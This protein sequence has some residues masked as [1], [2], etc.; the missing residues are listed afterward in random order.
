[1]VNSVWALCMQNRMVLDGTLSDRLRQQRNA[2][3]IVD[4]TVIHHN[5]NTMASYSD[6]ICYDNFMIIVEGGGLGFG[7]TLHY[8]QTR[9]HH[10]NRRCWLRYQSLKNEHRHTLANDEIETISIAGWTDLLRRFYLMARSN[11]L[12]TNAIKHRCDRENTDIQEHRFGLNEAQC[13]NTELLHEMT[14]T[15]YHAIDSKYWYQDQYIFI[16]VIDHNM[17]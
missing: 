9:I 15:V 13:E 10:E 11:V 3:V 4:A 2:P 6:R 7:N 12:H 17:T 14:S 8:L 1:M 16:P 5:H